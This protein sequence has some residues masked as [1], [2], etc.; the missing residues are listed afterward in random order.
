[1]CYILWTFGF[2]F[3]QEVVPLLGCSAATAVVAE[4]NSDCDL[5]RAL[6]PGSICQTLPKD[7]GNAMTSVGLKMLH[8]SIVRGSLR[9]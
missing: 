5:F 9:G 7:T 4:I 8:H 3:L 1:M 2:A 6:L